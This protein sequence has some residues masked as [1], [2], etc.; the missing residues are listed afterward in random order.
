MDRSPPVVSQVVLKMHS[1]CDLACD[2]CYV[3]E[4]ADTSWRGR[5]RAV[6]H[7]ILAATAAGIAAHARAH[8]LPA[9]HVVLHGG[10]PLLAGPAL[11]RRAAEELHRA[12]R[13]VSALDLRIHTN[14]VL[15]DEEFCELFRELGVHVGISLD[16]DRA[17]NDRHR[18]YA[19][20][21]SSHAR[22][23]DA[24]ALL[25]RPRYREL[26]AGLLCTID[27][28]N[29]PVA[30]YDALAELAPPRIDFLLPHATWDHP[31]PRPRDRRRR[32]RTGWTPCTGAGTGRGARFPYGSSN[33]SGAPCAAAPASPSPWGS[34]RPTWWSSRPTAPSNRRT[35]SRRP[36][37]APRPPG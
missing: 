30:V 5:P 12:L 2:H 6:S 13:G 8:R 29:D 10:E 33:P 37:T 4:H 15:L 31:P 18:R 26:F 3:Y 28:E 17:A 16:G 36:T 27:L 14:G 19:D 32:T 20:G 7:E 22:V 34:P 11:L 24:I 9:V 23:L 1:R 25:G 35:A 21:R